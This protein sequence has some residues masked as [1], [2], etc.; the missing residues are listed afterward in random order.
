MSDFDKARE[1]LREF[2][3]D[4]YVCGSGVLGEVGRMTA[5]LGRRSALVRSTYQGTDAIVKRVGESLVAAGVEVLGEIAGAAPNAP[6]EDVFRISQS[7]AALDSDVIVALGAGS[8]I[9]AT[10]AAEVLRALGGPIDQYFSLGAVTAKLKATGKTLLPIVA[11]QTAS[12]SAAHLTKF[13]AITD[14]SVGQKKVM[15]D[16]ACVPARAVYD[17]DLSRSMSPAF[18][19]DG[20]LDGVAHALEPLYESVGKPHFGKMM[21]LAQVVVSLVVNYVERAMKNPDDSEARTA[22]GL[23][24]DL[25]AYTV[26]VGRTNGGHMT[27]FSLVDILSHGRACAIMNPY[28]T[29]F[30]ASRIEEPLRMV[31]KIFKDAGLT[32]AEIDKLRGRELGIAVAEAM[33]ALGKR[34]GF[35]T[36]LGEV[37]GFS[38]G[39]IERA[40]AAAADPQ[41]KVKFI[42]A[43]PVQISDDTIDEYLRP[44]LLAAKTGDLSLIK[45]VP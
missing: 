31:G 36:T 32:D 40:M 9:D 18:T 35:P 19:A 39:H 21:E 29:V 37:E 5:E 41:I 7:L 24:T 4:N 8:T 42:D 25:G 28:Y 12:S 13:A 10:K 17:Y 20:A 15:V 23:A 16:M 11:V 27:S 44:I 3:G 30:F 6:R 1:L 38:D 26:M 43:M 22:L 14:V 34:V 45:N 33:I 2:K